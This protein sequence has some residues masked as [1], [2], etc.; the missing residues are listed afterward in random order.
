MGIASRGILDGYKSEPMALRQLGVRFVSH[1]FPGETLAVQAWRS[2]E[3]IYFEV[4]VKEREVV[5]VK[6][7]AQLL[8]KPA[9]NKCSF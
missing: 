9:E 5:C 1:V 4:R 8:Q 7:L 2:P 6:G 3:S